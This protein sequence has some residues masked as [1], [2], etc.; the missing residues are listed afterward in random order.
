MLAESKLTEEW[1]S[2]KRE[3][4]GSG[5]VWEGRGREEREE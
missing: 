2:F 3:G 5:R 1:V 4:K